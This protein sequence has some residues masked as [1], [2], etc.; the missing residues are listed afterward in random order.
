MPV[1]RLRPQAEADL[2]SRI[3]RGRL[4]EPDEV[5]ALI[6]FL[7]SDPAGAITGQTIAVD[8]GFAGVPVY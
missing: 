5:S 3:P 7:V 8:G 4:I 2:L 1:L 6:A